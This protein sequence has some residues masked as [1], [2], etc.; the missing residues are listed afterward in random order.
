MLRLI[1]H[2]EVLFF[3]CKGLP[4]G[5]TQIEVQQEYIIVGESETHG[6][7]H[8]VAVADKLKVKAYKDADGSL[9]MTNLDKTKVFCPKREKHG[10]SELPE[11]VWEIVKANE[12]DYVTNQVRE[13]RD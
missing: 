12:F 11:S 5:L 2:G 7:D 10:E 1:K 6:N 9:Y 4:K 3:E 8:R 13:V